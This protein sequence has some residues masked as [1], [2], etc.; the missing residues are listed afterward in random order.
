[1]KITKLNKFEDY[2]AEKDVPF[3]SATPNDDGS[4]TIVFEDG[5]T[6]KLTIGLSWGSVSLELEWIE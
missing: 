3:T 6:A 1:M 2:I 5:R 4:L